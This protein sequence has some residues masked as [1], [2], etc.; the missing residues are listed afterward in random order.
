MPKPNLKNQL[1][2]AFTSTLQ[3]TRPTKTVV[4]AD[5]R[6]VD[7]VAL[8]I[9]PPSPFR[10]RRDDLRSNLIISY[11]AAA[12]IALHA[13]DKTLSPL[14]VEHATENDRTDTRARGWRHSLTTAELEPGI[15]LEPGLLGWF[16]LTPLGLQELGDKLYGFTSGVA[17]GV[18]L[19][20]NELHLTELKS[21]ALTNNPAAY[22]AQTFSAQPQPQH[23]Q[24]F[25]IT[26]YTTQADQSATTKDDEM[27]KKLLLALGLAETADEAT[28]LAAVTALTA[29]Q[30]QAA[31]VAATVTT[32]TAQRDTDTVALTA[33]RAEVTTLTATVT[34]LT[35]QLTALKAADADRVVLSAVDAA[36]SARKATPAQRDSLLALAKLDVVAFNAAM[37]A[38]PAVL[39]AGNATHANTSAPAETFG[40]TADE[41]ATA[42][43]A[44][45]KDLQTYSEQRAKARSQLGL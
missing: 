26:V 43:A 5:G 9:F 21:T 20:E 30:T 15:G 45:V 18:R 3:T 34:D 16:E 6:T 14:D 17:H 24:T 12:L 39:P 35:T 32:L 31:D 19:S 27:L 22:T 1:T 28:A 41:V 8:Q 7:L 4:T 36:I 29:A 23:A 10:T 25:N 44:G 37:A 2:T 13:N 11:D 33:A 38:A 40:L 42:K